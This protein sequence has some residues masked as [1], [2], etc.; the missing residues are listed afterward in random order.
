MPCAASGGWGHFAHPDLPGWPFRIASARALPQS[1]TPGRHEPQRGFLGRLI[2]RDPETAQPATAPVAPVQIAETA[3]SRLALAAAEWGHLKDTPSIAK[4]KRFAEHFRGTYYAEL[5][6][7]RIAELEEAD[8][9]AKAEAERNRAEAETRTKQEAEARCRQ[10][11]EEARRNAEGERI[12]REEADETGGRAL[13]A[14][15]L[16]R[17]ADAMNCGGSRP[18]PARA[19]RTS[20]PGR[21]WL[22]SRRANS[23]WARRPSRKAAKMPKGRSIRLDQSPVRARP[24]CRHA[25]GVRRLCRHGPSH[26]R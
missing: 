11:Q 5:A 3:G 4:L 6:A 17:A 20:M 12:A 24:L 9:Q 21:R 1:G 14:W 10:E 22:L 25:G 8:A 13:C 26:A 15:L 18:V 19:S 7:E 16:G 23:L 2:N